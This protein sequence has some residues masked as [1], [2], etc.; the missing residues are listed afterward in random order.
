MRRL[1]QRIAHNEACN[2]TAAWPVVKLVCLAP[3]VNTHS[4]PARPL[5]KIRNIVATTYQSNHP[6]VTVKFE[7]SL[8]RCTTHALQCNDV[9]RCATTGPGYSVRAG[10]Q[11]QP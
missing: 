7:P 10:V 2:S 1:G 9:Q 8:H 11:W 6:R 3:A 4:P 5:S